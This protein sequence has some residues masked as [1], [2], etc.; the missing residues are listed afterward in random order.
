MGLK[1]KKAK[2]HRQRKSRRKCNE[3][4]H[5]RK[6]SHQELHLHFGHCCYKSSWRISRRKDEFLHGTYLSKVVKIGTRA[7]LVLHMGH[8]S[9]ASLTNNLPWLRLLLCILHGMVTQRSCP[10]H[11][12]V[13]RYWVC[14]CSSDCRYLWSSSHWNWNN[15]MAVANK[16]WLISCVLNIVTPRSIFTPHLSYAFKPVL[17]VMK[18]KY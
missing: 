14:S 16:L 1:W 9:F 11:K 18:I 4:H 10:Q 17:Y 7:A 15:K 5:K 2:M 8:E 13:W 6:D 12:Q 3:E